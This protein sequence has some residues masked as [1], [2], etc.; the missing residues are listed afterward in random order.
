MVPK[1]KECTKTGSLPLLNGLW[2]PGIA[3]WDAAAE[4][5]RL[6]SPR[7][8]GLLGE[9][10]AQITPK[11]LG[12]H[13][14]SHTGSRRLGCDFLPGAAA[15]E[16]KGGQ[17]SERIFGCFSSGT[18]KCPALLKLEAYTTPRI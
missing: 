8:E 12:L 17:K 18:L 14:H 5:S 1:G 10:Q 4:G 7:A 16:D 15:A 2:G 13:R 9:E 6:F 11:G 3:G